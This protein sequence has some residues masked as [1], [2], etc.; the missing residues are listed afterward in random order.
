MRRA[1]AGGRAGGYER[2]GD[3]FTG[4]HGIIGVQSDTADRT[5]RCTATRDAALLD[6]AAV[7]TLFAD[8]LGH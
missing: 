8:I 7:A 6:D 2:I 3:G 1:L 5:T 4:S